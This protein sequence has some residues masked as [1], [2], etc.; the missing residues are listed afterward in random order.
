[1][2][3]EINRTKQNVSFPF[4]LITVSHHQLFGTYFSLCSFVPLHTLCRGGVSSDSGPH[5]PKTHPTAHLSFALQLLF[6]SFS[7]LSS[8]LS[9][10]FPLPSPPLHPP[11]ASLHQ[12]TTT[13]NQSL[14][15]Q[16]I[17]VLSFWDYKYRPPLSNCLMISFLLKIF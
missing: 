13:P 10:P 7:F 6:P 5:M 2:Q 11:S 9:S 15:T 3:N 12:P 4:R 8:F 17:L 14:T 16:L 1:M